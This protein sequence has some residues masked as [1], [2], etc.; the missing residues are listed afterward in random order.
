MIYDLIVIGGGPA[1][2]N[3]AI[4]AKR[5]GKNV[6]ILEKNS[7]GGVIA[8]TGVVENYLG[9]P[10]VNGFEL[11]NRFFEHLKSLD[12][13]YDLKEV[14]DIELDGSKKR[15]I[16]TS[17][18]ILAKNI[19]VAT[20]RRPKLLDLTNSREL[21]GK[22]ISTCAQCD[23]NFFKGKNVAVV[24][25]SNSAVDEALYLSNIVDKV[26]LIHRKN[27]F[28]A[29]IETVEKAKERDNIE[30]IYDANVTKINSLDDRL[31]SIE[32]NKT[33]II[34]VSG[35]FMYVGY[36]PNTEFLEKLNILDEKGYVIVDSK[37]ET[38]IEGIFACG[39]IIKKDYY[40]L[41][42]AAS[43]GMLAALYASKH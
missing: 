20:G 22:G 10:N 40:Q 36:T 1:G 13:A 43:D 14:L 39:D 33:R 7:F 30:I 28:S 18:V 31:S 38:N 41:I 37:F 21:L 32:V 2:I 9:I 23:A 17:G 35:L 11:S 15:V 5:S 8:T 27:D 26:Y 24:G 42:G 3:A 16:T 4:Y 19:I 29:D 34:E 12:I 25:G 6:L